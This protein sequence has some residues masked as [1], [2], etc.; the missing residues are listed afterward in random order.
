VVVVLVVVVA[1]V[2]VVVVLAAGAEQANIEVKT[3]DELIVN[4]EDVVG[5]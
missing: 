4:A 5:E 1:A 3:P 2:V